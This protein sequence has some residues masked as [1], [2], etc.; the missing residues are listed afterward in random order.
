MIMHST[1]FSTDILKNIHILGIN[2]AKFRIALKG[3][4][5]NKPVSKM[6]EK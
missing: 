2:I 5:T 3:F 1:D 4:G 6:L